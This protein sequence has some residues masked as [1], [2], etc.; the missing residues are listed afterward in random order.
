MTTSPYA[1]EA[2]FRDLIADLDDV[3]DT[4]KR[5]EP[6]AEIEARDLFWMEYAVGQAADF[7]NYLRLRIDEAAS[8]RWEV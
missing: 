7:L 2:Q 5:I 4:I 6:G 3:L 8:G 1:R